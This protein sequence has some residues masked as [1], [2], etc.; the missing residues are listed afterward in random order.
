MRACSHS[1]SVVQ[2]GAC[3][4]STSQ[5]ASPMWSGWKCVTTTRVIGRPSRCSAKMCSHASRVSGSAKPLSTAVQP[6]PSSSSHRLM[7]LS[8]NGSLIRSQKMPGAIGHDFAGRGRRLDGKM[9][10]AVHVSSSLV[11]GTKPCEAALDG[12]CELTAK[13][14]RCMRERQAGSLPGWIA[15]TQGITIGDSGRRT[16]RCATSMYRAARRRWRP[17][18]WSRPRTRGRP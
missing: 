18:A 10:A 15:P 6:G 16:R 11:D 17:T 1:F 9:Q 5:A 8:A 3:Q 14:G 2:N 12:L 7:W 13:V 4:R